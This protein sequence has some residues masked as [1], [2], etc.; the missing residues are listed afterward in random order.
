MTPLHAAA[1]IGNK[2]GIEALIEAKANLDAKDEVGRRGRGAEGG[3]SGGEGCG[4]AAGKDEVPRRL[5]AGMT[6]TS[7]RRGRVEKR[8]DVSLIQDGS[9]SPRPPCL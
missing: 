5:W 1:S 2:K 3:R 8:V 4:S 7:Q 9:H 6:R